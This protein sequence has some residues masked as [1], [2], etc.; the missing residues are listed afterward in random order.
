M[1]ICSET[2]KTYLATATEFFRCDLYEITLRSGTVLRYADYDQQITLADERVFL[3]TGPQFQRGQ[4]KLTAKIEVDSL[5]VSVFV[6]STDLIGSIS[7]MKAAQLGLFDDADLTLYKCF[8]SSPGV[9]VEALEWFS[10]YVDVKT[11]GGLEMEW[12]INSY[13][14]RLNVDYPVRRYYPTC[15]YSLYDYNCGAVIGSFTTA[16]HVVTAVSKKEITTDLTFADD[17]Y[18]L[19]GLTFTSGA[20]SGVSIAIEKS[21]HTNGRLVLIISL[22]ALPTAGDHFNVYPGCDKTPE[23]CNSKF[24]NVVY[25]RSTPFIPLKET[26]Q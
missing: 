23:M 9:V 5:D 24:N 12:K 22:D 2:L 7:W 13:M 6:E 11:G 26:I 19:G 8:M 25:N 4:T 18:D 14:Q 3:A 20:L 21:Y 17:Y 15:P 16:G 1:K 10:G